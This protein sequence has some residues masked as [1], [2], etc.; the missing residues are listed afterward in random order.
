M[1][2]KGF[3]F[4]ET[5]I[6]TAIILASLMLV[7]SLFVAS[8][9]NEKKRLRY[10]DPAKLYETFY[11]KN[12]LESFY[13]DT[14]KKKI[15]NKSVF[16]QNI[17]GQSDLFG[18]YYDNEKKFFEEMKSNLHIE[19]IL[20]TP[21]DVSN[22]TDCKSKI[23]CSN[24]NLLEYLKTLDNDKNTGYRLIIEFREARSGGK[25]EGTHDCYNYFSNVR[26]EA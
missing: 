23:L 7:Y 16:Y 3:V 9:N 17:Y 8:N 22:L 19:N 21:Y 14:L 12:Y 1:N 20:L 10:D 2:K 5:I 25:C 26:I 13:L 11:V 24:L 15:D 6:V 4:V 18:G